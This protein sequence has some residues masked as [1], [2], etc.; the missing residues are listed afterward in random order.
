MTFCCYCGRPE[1]E[2]ATGFYDSETG[3]AK[4]RM[5]CEPCEESEVRIRLFLAFVIV[6][7]LL[8]MCA[9]ITG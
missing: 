8:S 9:W 1:T 7:P 4:T 2:R 5:V 3:Q 6:T